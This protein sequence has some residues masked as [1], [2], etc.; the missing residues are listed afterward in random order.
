V[1]TRACSE[2]KLRDS[3]KLEAP[4]MHILY[5]HQ[6]FTPP[7]GC[8]STRSYEMAR[9][10]VAA[11]HRVTL[12]T[13]DAFFPPSYQWPSLVTAM[14]LDGIELK[15]IRAKYSNKQSYIRRILAFFYFAIL[16]SWVALRIGKVDLIFATSTP[17]TIM[18]PAV[19]AKHLKR[20]AMVFEVRDQ[21]PSVPIA[22]GILRNRIAI[23]IARQMERI[24][25]AEASHIVALSP[26]TADGIRSA[27]V[28]A[29]KIS[30]VPNCSD[31]EFFRSASGIHNSFLEQHPQFKDKKIVAYAGTLGFANGVDYLIALAAQLKT[32]LPDVVFAIV[33]DGA[34]R[35]E[36]LALS[37]ELGVH[38]VNTWILPPAPKRDVASLFASAT[39]CASTF[40]KEAAP[41]PNSAN[42]FFDALA[43]GKPII[44]NYG[45]WQKSLLENSGAGIALPTSDIEAAAKSLTEYLRDTDALE[46]ACAASRK[47]GET[48]F[49]RNYWAR[50]LMMILEQAAKNSAPR[51]D[52]DIFTQAGSPSN[53][54]LASSPSLERLQFPNKSNSNEEHV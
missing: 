3:Y 14:N 31:I 26:P 48:Q 52:S 17:L 53:G 42:K 25:Y 22:L 35:R 36:L 8:G 44:V 46:K 49:N 41:W 32:S 45:G 29:E 37:Q 27:G 30:V 50:K 12:V 10:F 39:V 15:V 54:R 28:P 19:L 9:R 18:I 40:I 7:D 16:S 6:Y 34:K 24:A 11:G 43:A 33:G 1:V 38:H 4:E 47:I 21:W 5:L 51:T 20:A 13:S 23:F 2:G